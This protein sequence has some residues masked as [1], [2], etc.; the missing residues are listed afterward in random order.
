MAIS[1]PL[2]TMTATEKFEAFQ[3]LWEDLCAHSEDIPIPEWQVQALREREAA[4][5]RGEEVAMDLDDAMAMI[6][7]ELRCE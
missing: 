2:D 4:I 5:A 6:R 1:I 7:E 3:L